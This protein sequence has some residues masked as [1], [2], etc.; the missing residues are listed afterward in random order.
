MKE[1]VLV[2]PPIQ[3]PKVFLGL[4][5]KKSKNILD[6]PALEVARQITLIDF[7]IFKKIE[8]KECL[9]QAWNS[10]NRE[11]Q[12]PNIAQ[13]IKRFNKLSNWVGSTVVQTTDLDQRI[14]V[15]TKFIDITNE[16]KKLNN[17]NSLFALCSGLGL[18]S[19]FRLK[20]TWNV[21]PI[22]D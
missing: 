17:F 2:C 13:M 14:K 16:L 9:N 6:W 10:K 18:A 8:P 4:G 21:W 3:Y 15:V 7:N 22:F 12:A 19:V 5:K 20:K 11:T 1:S